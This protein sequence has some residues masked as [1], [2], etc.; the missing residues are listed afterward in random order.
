MA[1]TNEEMTARLARDVEDGWVLN[2]GT[3]LPTAVADHLWGRDVLVQSENGIVG[4]GPRSPAG[5]ED[6]DVVDAGKNF[7]T[8]L[9]GAAFLDSSMSFGLIRSHRLN[10]SVMGAFQVS[11]S[12]D[13]ANWKQP[14]SRLAGIGGAADLAYGAQ[15]V[16]VLMSHTNKKGDPKIVSRCDFPLTAPGAVRRI[17]TELGM[18]E[19][20][21]NGV[22]VRVLAPG[23]SWTELET[24]TDAS[25]TDAREEQ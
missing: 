20:T 21:V 13:L 6:L 17:Y 5:Q 2:L 22:V 8:V 3:G 11:A 4:V 7:V 1:W 14:N 15:Q 23:V 18:F 9:P 12:G 25:L 24:A 16:W 19:V 10:L